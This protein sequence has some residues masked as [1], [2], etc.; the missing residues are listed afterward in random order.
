M[1][2]VAAHQGRG[3]NEKTGKG[4]EGEER[5]QATYFKETACCSSVVVQ[6]TAWQK[7]GLCNESA[8]G[9]CYPREGQQPLRPNLNGVGDRTT[10]LRQ[11]LIGA[12]QFCSLYILYIR[13]NFCILL[14][15]KIG[16]NTC[17]GDGQK[18]PIDD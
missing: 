7:N 9:N 4:K 8:R 10:T 12:V 5:R 16:V 18:I 3:N 2:N 6:G 17:F 14:S 13:Q 15:E 11:L 1:M